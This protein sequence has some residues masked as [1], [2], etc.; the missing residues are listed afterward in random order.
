MTSTLAKEAVKDR[1]NRRLLKDITSIAPEAVDQVVRLLAGDTSAI[2][3]EFR[4]QILQHPKG[5]IWLGEALARAA[6]VQAVARGEVAA[7]KA[8][9]LLDSEDQKVAASAA[10]ALIRAGEASMAGIERVASQRQQ[11]SHERHQTEV[12]LALLRG[13]DPEAIEAETA[14]GDDDA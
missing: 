6:R 14:D 1:D 2:D 5:A 8:I 7:N 12:V 3:T 13:G 10:T 9:E 4:R 11:H